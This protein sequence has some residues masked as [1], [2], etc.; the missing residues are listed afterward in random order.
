MNGVA[1]IT[2]HDGGRAD[3]ALVQRFRQSKTT[4]ERTAVFADVVRQHRH[5][6]LRSCAE[7]L[8]PDAD[9]A[10]AAA[11]GVLV[12]ARL[13]M[14]DPAK[15]PRP[16]RLRGWL[17]GIV[18]E[19]CPLPGRPG[20]IDDV[21]WEAVR[22]RIAVGTPEMPDSTVGRG[23]LR[24]W[25]ERIVA[26]LPEPRQRMYDLFVARG[27]DSRNA[28]REL[29]TTVAEVRRLRGENRQ[30]ILRAFE[31]TAL[32][33]E[34]A[35]DPPATRAP[36]CGELRQTLADARGG[37]AD[38]HDGGRR[39]TAVLSA[40]LRLTLSRHL[41][42]C[43]TCQD[44]RDD[45]MARWAPELLPIL[46]DAELHERVMEDVQATP[47][48]RQPGDVPGAHRR[49]APAGPVRKVV[50]GRVAVASAGAGV[51]A[52][53]LLIAFVW[54]GVL[55]GT[56]AATD[57]FSPDRNKA[58]TSGVDAPT[59]AGTVNGIPDNKNRR[60]A[61]PGGG[62]LL[63]TL[64]PT[65]T[66]SPAAASSSA[67]VQPSVYYT[68]P[69]STAPTSSPTQPP[70]A[71]SPSPSQSRTTSPTPSAST[72]TPTPTPTASTSTPTPTPTASTSTPTPTP[73]ASTSTPTPT[74][75]ASTPTP[76]PS[77][78]TSETSEPTP[79]TS[80]SSP[81]SASPTVSSSTV[82]PSASATT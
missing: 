61:R 79:T 3:A 18:S 52:A 69:P 80:A 64:P 82:A 10:V 24:Q 27:L 67:S 43:R 39:P 17:L 76:T 11:A 65:A 75:S 23:S 15:L 40:A 28:A 44:R 32:A 42:E 31:V 4:R 49:V 6:V 25:L 77:A 38:P 46:A 33:A 54:P 81:T 78:S 63:S 50:I 66:E 8:W 48:P 68:V 7:R 41:S 20:R 16:D 29:G 55:H 59:V 9:G 26:T 37:D 47:E 73:S 58:V 30:A 53:L 71:P 1:T 14:A 45:C 35:V 34:A 62:G 56:R 5:A 60:P 13:A 36:G 57:A 21:N 74:T 72:S 19:A 70:A 51:L 22:A 2:A 12:A